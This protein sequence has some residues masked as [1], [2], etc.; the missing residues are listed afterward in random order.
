MYFMHVHF[1]FHKNGLVCIMR[2]GTYLGNKC[3][4]VYAVAHVKLHIH[5]LLQ[6]IINAYSCSSEIQYMHK[7]LYRLVCALWLCLHE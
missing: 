7:Q 6:L 2:V 5:V 3:S 4:Y 1:L